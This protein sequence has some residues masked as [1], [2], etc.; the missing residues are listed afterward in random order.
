MAAW[1]A[2]MERLARRGVDSTAMPAGRFDDVHECSRPDF[3][4]DRVKGRLAGRGPSA[5]LVEAS[6]SQAIFRTRIVRV[7]TMTLPCA[8]ALGALASTV[9]VHPGGRSHWTSWS[10]SNVPAFN[11]IV[12]RSVAD[13]A[14]VVDAVRPT[15]FAVES[16]IAGGAHDDDDH[17]F[18]FNAPPSSRSL[19]SGRPG[20]AR[21]STRRRLRSQG[22][23][24]FISADGYAVTNS[25]VV[26][27]AES[28]RIVTDDQKTYAAK[29][30][31]S[32]SVSDLAL[33]KVDGRND[34]PFVRF[35][36]ELPRVGSW[37]LAIGN[38]F[39]LSGTVTAGIVSARPR[40]LGPGSH[41][42]LIQIDAPV[43]QGDSGGPSFDLD[44][45][46]I[47]VNTMILSPTGGSIGIAF[48]IPAQTVKAVV[49]Q[50]MDKGAVARA[51][52]GV[53]LLPVMVNI[54]DSPMM[55]GVQ[56]ALVALAE[57]SSP[58]AQAGIVPGDVIT[59]VNG[60]P[61]KQ[62]SDLGRK[63]ADSAPGTSLSLDVV[64]DGER[65]TVQVTLGQMPKRGTSVAIASGH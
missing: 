3:D 11:K 9:T 40:N 37:I 7:L 46:V 6:M 35:A 32:D 49:P 39:G 18:D 10:W 61:I 4:I 5:L 1:V 27:N 64:H 30:V 57:A 8:L 47:G 16:Q 38:P 51:W 25:H 26:E 62:I 22:S 33:L 31:G 15:V 48:A 52:L 54:S 44:G 53:Q 41:Q 60:D 29:V 14:D 34:F 24:F 45:K 36:D 23:G 12:S 63:L 65:K 17:N 56:G 58:A 13:F 2:G 28:T 55:K 43:N 21:P 20:E 59:S 19:P 42:E 50:L